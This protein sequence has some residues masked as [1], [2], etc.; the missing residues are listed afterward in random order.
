[1]KIDP[2]LPVIAELVLERFRSE[3]GRIATA[4]SCTGGLISAL[5]TSVAGS[6]D[7]FERGFATYSNEAKRDIIGVDEATL[8]MF[9]AVSMETAIEMATGALENSQATASVAVT[10]IAGPGGGTTDKPVGLV[11]IAV[12]NRREEGAIGEEF[13]FGDRSRDTIRNETVK[14][15]FEM[16]LAYGL[17]SEEN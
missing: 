9:G 5:L 2:E 17:L 15:A 7:V 1:M 10:G 3:N 13:R 8:E 6:S 4:E 16:L 12:A 14:Q 11:Y